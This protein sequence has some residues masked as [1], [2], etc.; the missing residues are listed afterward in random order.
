MAK[1]SKNQKLILNY[2]ELKP[3]MTAKELAEMILINCKLHLKRI[4]LD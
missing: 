1:L 4:Q 3:E 2:L